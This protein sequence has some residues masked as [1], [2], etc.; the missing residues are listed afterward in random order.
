M[1][2]SGVIEQY[3]QQFSV[4]QQERLC[5][6]RDIIRAA[7][8]AASERISWQMPT[9]YL[10]GNL[11]HFAQQKN[12]IGFYPGENGVKYYLEHRERLGE[13]KNSKGAI[14]FPQNEPLPHNLISEIV[15]F[16]VGENTA[17]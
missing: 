17:K 5:E 8:P 3:I 15:K 2:D 10:N 1:A 12:H 14:Q 9:F 11:V 16:R 7:A 4:T 6:I 13:Y